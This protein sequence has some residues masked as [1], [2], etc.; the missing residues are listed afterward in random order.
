MCK[1]LIMP[2]IKDNTREQVLK[3]VDLMAE[4]MSNANSDGLGYAA[5][6]KNG[7]LFGERWLVNKDFYNKTVED[8]IVN[9]LFGMYSKKNYATT[10]TSK[11]EYNRFG[12]GNLNNAVAITLHARM[13]TS[14]KGHQNTHPFVDQDTSLIHN[15]VIRNYD[16]KDLKLSTCDSEAILISYLKNNVATDLSQIQTVAQELVGYYACGVFARDADGER[17][18]DVFKANN[19][20]LW[21]SFI[22]TID[23]YVLTT[24]GNDIRTVCGK[25]GWEFEEPIQIMDGW[26]AR[27]NP[28]TGDVI[29]QRSFRES[30]QYVATQSNHNYTGYETWR[31]ELKEEKVV[32][33]ARPT[34]KTMSKAMFDYLQLKPEIIPYAERDQQE[35]LSRWSQ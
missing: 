20:N 23:T 21:A 19:D 33:L 9:K 10:T 1:V 32:P 17:I 7:D 4:A 6:D 18:L 29:E 27:L 31:Q 34:K 25:L 8:P 2:R 13:A 28:Y 5:V 3:F 30:V 22:P 26:A 24:S 16:V 14:G 11:S 35:E 15:G 12:K